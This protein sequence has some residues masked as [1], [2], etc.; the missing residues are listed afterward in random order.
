[1]EAA[2]LLPRAE[3][4]AVWKV[5]APNGRSI[6]IGGSVHALRSADYPLPA[7]FN[8]AFDASSRIVFEVD[9]KALSGSGKSLLQ[10]GEYPKGDSLKNHVDPRTYDY[11]RRV[12][13][14]MG[15]PE[16]KFARYRPWFLVLVLQAPG[17][18]GFSDQLGVDHFLL[19]RAK[20]NRKTVL[21]LESTR[22]HAE[23]FS[24]LTDRQGEL[25]LL[26]SFLP[27]QGK[28]FAW[29]PAWRRGDVDALARVMHDQY[30]E[31]P[32]FA[33]RILDQRNRRWMPKIE[34][35]LQSGHTHF[36]VVGAGHLGGPAGVLT[37]LR[38]RGYQVSQL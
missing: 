11:V 12:F 2:C 10:A 18:H 22:E 31:F 5:T 29:L 23:V 8:R 3:A 19:Q 20:A 14:L 13:G 17:L 24:G 35:Y 33:V 27:G 6:Y 15:V 36:V 16:A 30:R 38:A 26:H 28:K 7:A 34:G 4:A 21:G 32:S 25:L 9:E 1:M 37:M